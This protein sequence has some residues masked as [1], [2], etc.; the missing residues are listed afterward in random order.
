MG[1]ILLEICVEPL[2]IT[3]GH[4]GDKAM[5]LNLPSE[6]WALFAAAVAFLLAPLLL[7]YIAYRLVR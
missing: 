1:F 3:N 6:I 7:L 4:T 5:P 2:M